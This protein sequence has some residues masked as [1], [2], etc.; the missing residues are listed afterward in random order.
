MAFWN[1]KRREA[2]P[3]DTAAPENKTVS[4]RSKSMLRKGKRTYGAVETGGMVTSWTTAPKTADQLTFQTL[5]I[6]RARSRDQFEG[7]DFARRFV[8]LVKTHVVGPDGFILQ[9]NVTGLDGKQDE[10]AND[11]IEKN[12]KQWQR[13]KF[14]DAAMRLHFSDVCRLIMGTLA[15]DGEVIIQRRM[16]V[17]F[18]VYQYAQKFIDPELLDVGLNQDL[19]NG[20]K[21][22]FGIEFDD[23]DRPVAYYFRKSTS[24]LYGY[25]SIEDYTRVNAS[26]IKHLF[27]TER[28]GQKRG[29]PWLATP[30]LRMQMLDAYGDT[31]LTVARAGAAK[32]I[33]YKQNPEADGSL[34]GIAELEE[35]GQ[36]VESIDPGS[37]NILPPG[38]DMESYDPTYPHAQF[39]TFVKTQLRSIAAGLGVSYHKLAN[40]LEGVNYSSGRLGELED[41]EIWKRLQTWLIESYLRPLYEDWLTLQLRMGTL[42]VPTRANGLR[43]L[44]GSPEKYMAVSFQGRRWA[45]TDPGK[46][47]KANETNLNNYLTSP[48]KVLR[49]AGHDPEEIVNDWAK[50]RDML[51]EKGFSLPEATNLTQ[52]TGGDDADEND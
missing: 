28:V 29:V 6:L 35:E 22:R 21:V 7:N 50:W 5:R 8:E 2:P 52:E 32:S 23:D 45:W 36:L 13:A 17:K 19:K 14:C 27:V 38:V 30:L 44:S 43:P 37:A 39:D 1:R 15:T 40:D 9:G 25:N 4:V 26:E 12:W 42:T 41:R 34:S 51:A 10:L 20:N 11:S 48:Q 47:A 24:Q 49:E 31:A 46:E 16:G 33:F 3:E 18:G